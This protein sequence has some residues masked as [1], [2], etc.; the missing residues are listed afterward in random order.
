MEQFPRLERNFT[1]DGTPY[2]PPRWVDETR[3][4]RVERVYYLKRR[5]II[6]CTLPVE[7][8]GNSTPVDYDQMRSMHTIMNDYLTGG[9]WFDRHI[10]NLTGLCYYDDMIL[11][12]AAWLTGDLNAIVIVEDKYDLPR[13]NKPANYFGFYLRLLR[14]AKLMR[15]SFAY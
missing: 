10:A 15:K 14:I 7:E 5:F 1:K 13:I 9:S 6:G 8:L 12:R 11:L 4:T 3:F 2:I